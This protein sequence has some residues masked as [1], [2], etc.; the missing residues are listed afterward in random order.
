[1][2]APYTTGCTEDAHEEGTAHLK[3]QWGAIDCQVPMWSAILLIIATEPHPRCI[4]DALRFGGR[5]GGRTVKKRGAER[6][7]CE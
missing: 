3:P 7:E 4:V 1:M 5:E 6:R 2:V